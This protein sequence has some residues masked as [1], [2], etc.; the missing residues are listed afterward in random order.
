MDDQQVSE[1]GNSVIAAP[2]RAVVAAHAGEDNQGQTRRRAFA[3]RL[4]VSSSLP[5]TAFEPASAVVRYRDPQPPSRYLENRLVHAKTT[6][7][8]YF[9]SISDTQ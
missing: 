1:P 6:N 4:N 7:T 3:S 2:R 5:F 9:L 8:I